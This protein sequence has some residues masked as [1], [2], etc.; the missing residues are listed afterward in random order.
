MRFSLTMLRETGL[1][2]KVFGWAVT[3]LLLLSSV[4]EGVPSLAD[5][6]NLPI[7]VVGLCGLFLY[8]YSKRRFI[9]LLW[10]LYLPCLVLW[11][12]VLSLLKYL[13]VS[14]GPQ[15]DLYILFGWII[16]IPMYAALFLYAFAWRPT[17]VLRRAAKPETSGSG[18]PTVLPVSAPGL[19]GPHAWLSRKWSDG[20][21][22]VRTRLLPA[23]PFPVAA[24]LR[25]GKIILACGLV[26]LWIVAHHYVSQMNGLFFQKSIPGISGLVLYLTGNYN[27]TAQAYRAH[28]AKTYQAGKTS[29]DPILDALLRRDLQSA[30]TFTEQA[31]AN[32]PENNEARLGQGELALEANDPGRA[33]E[34]FEHVLKQDPDHIDALLLASI[35]HARAGHSDLAIDV[36]KRSLRNDRL[37][38]RP[39]GFFALLETTGTLSHLPEGQKPMCLLAIYYRYLQ[40]YDGSNG[41]T[42]IAYAKK[43]IAARDRPADAY[44]VIGIVNERQGRPEKA[45]AA[46]LDAVDADPKQ[47]EAYRR[48]AVVYSSRGD[49]FLNEY[50]MWKGA[51][52]AEPLDQ[53]Y[54]DAYIQF[55]YKR[56]GDFPSALKILLPSVERWPNNLDMLA[57]T[58]EL[59]AWQGEYDQ[60]IFYNRKVLELD[61]GR[62]EIHVRIGY[63]LYESDRPEEAIGE[64]RAA[65]A[66]A[67]NYAQPH[68]GLAAVYRKA[69][70]WEEAIPEYE[71]ALRMGAEDV[72]F[73]AELCSLY[74][75]RE[76]YQQALDC[77]KIVIKQDPENSIARQTLPYTLK[78]LG[79]LKP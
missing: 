55:L 41:K 2:W 37:G 34:A 23:L 64:Y 72:D 21:M 45:L 15:T 61:P 12:L 42:A 78:N 68:V 11:D 16:S 38:S 54:A 27:G 63:S 49:D 79:L 51:F 58:G 73:R 25:P 46:F 76:Q 29:G 35:A 66:L 20:A 56:L 33:L 65:V 53:F 59:Y 77:F 62:A 14:T 22:W 57:L 9:P 28:F 6:A 26:A 69:N 5:K 30:K 52:D 18:Q 71:T 74:H 36:F 31:L 19:P 75:H 8:S 39:T 3:F 17:L 44:L 60:S 43:A 40:L 70:R 10:K 47:A 13:F 4:M 24:L 1:P 32:D 7:T 67:P 50:R 48:A